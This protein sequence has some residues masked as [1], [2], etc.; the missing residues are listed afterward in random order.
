MADLTLVA[1]NI[2]ADFNAVIVST[3]VAGVALTAG[4]VVYADS[5]DSGELK[6]AQH[7]GTAAEAA[8]VGI[9]LADAADTEA[10]TY[11]TSG[12]LALGTILTAGSVYVVSATPGKIAVDADPGSADFKTVVGVA[13]STSTLEVRFIIGGGVIL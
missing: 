2:V 1:L 4:D 12:E 13:K 9:V 8:A 3:G 11:I 5:T 6:L 10:V 7:D